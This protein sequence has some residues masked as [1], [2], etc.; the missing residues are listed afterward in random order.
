MA[1]SQSKSKQ[2]YQTNYKSTA[3][4]KTNRLKKLEQQLKLH[5][6][7]A[8]QIKLAMA[9]VG[10]YRRGTP[11]TPF[12]SH[13]MIRTAQLFKQF[14]GSAPH[15]LFSSNPQTAGAALQALRVNR[16]GWKPVEGKVSF[17]L[18]DRARVQITTQY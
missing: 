2:S 10:A 3:R 1:K 5:P 16:N 6:E 18:G 17:A 11:T 13:N 14:C 9:N 7:N 4:W 12:W 15:A 8:E